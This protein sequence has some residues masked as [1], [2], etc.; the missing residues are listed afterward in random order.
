MSWSRCTTTEELV[1][2]LLLE[3]SLIGMR[4]AVIC[5]DIGDTSY[6]DRCAGTARPPDRYLIARAASAEH[7]RSAPAVRP[8]VA[9]VILG[10]S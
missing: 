1:R 10:K 9:W 7:R 3:T 8:S 2:A 6:D 5:Q 4:I